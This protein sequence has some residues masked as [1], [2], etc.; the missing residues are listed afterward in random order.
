MSFVIKQI[1][2]IESIF[3]SHRAGRPQSAISRAPEH[4]VHVFTMKDRLREAMCRIGASTVFT[5]RDYLCGMECLADAGSFW[6]CAD[7]SSRLDGRVGEQGMTQRCD[8]MCV[9]WRVA[10]SVCVSGG[11]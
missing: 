4:T 7:F 2:F 1:V 9:G 11:T 6:C 8:C 3:A 10:A 5:R